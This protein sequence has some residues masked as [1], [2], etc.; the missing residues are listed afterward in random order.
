MSIF[1]PNSI[2]SDES[3]LKLLE[4]YKKFSNHSTSYKSI[5]TCKEW[6]WK[7]FSDLLT[8]AAR[9]WVYLD[10]KWTNFNFSSDMFHKFCYRMKN[11]LDS[12]SFYK[13]LSIEPHIK[14]GF[15]NR[16]MQ[17]L[18]TQ[19]HHRIHFKLKFIRC[20]YY[21]PSHRKICKSKWFRV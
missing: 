6:W 20:V 10:I 3:I 19:F 1:L 21:L 8:S 9:N 5:F 11:V 18:Q 4:S 17:T 13:K 7:P 12:W 15:V 14:S 16:Y 2:A